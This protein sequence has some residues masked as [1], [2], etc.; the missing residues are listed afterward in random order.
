MKKIIKSLLTSVA[1]IYLFFGIYLFIK[2]RDFIYYNTPL[3]VQQFQ[4]ETFINNGIKIKS[5][6][7]NE[8]K[9]DA[10]IYFGGNAKTVDYNSEIFTE[11]FP[12][13]SVYL[14]KYRGYSGS[15][16][17][18]TEENLYSDALY[19]YDKIKPRY[20]KMTIVGRSLGS[21]VA[22]FLA[23]QREIDKLVLIT[24]FDSVQNVTQD[25]FSLYPMS[26]ILKDKYDSVGRVKEIHSKT[27][28]I[29][30]Q[31]DQ[32]IQSERTKALVDAFPS[33]QLI[34]KIINQAGHNTIS[35]YYEYYETLDNF[36][37][38]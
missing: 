35:N 7:L 33:S 25:L 29:A 13:H 3:I 19:I 26:I 6:V 20:K 37:N 14:I 31:K 18:A 1:L 34:Y 23:S 36:I 16:G 28:I 38:H 11:K 17:D 12:N 9:E 15:E 4:E 2:Q 27:L 24:P 32:M 8:G 21:G 22:T 5:T 10:I 30:A